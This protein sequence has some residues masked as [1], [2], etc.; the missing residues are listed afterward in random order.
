MYLFIVLLICYNSEMK[1]NN[2]AKTVVKN[3]GIL[4][5]KFKFC[6]Q[7]LEDVWFRAHHFTSLNP[8]LHF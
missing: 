5:I 1:S 8:L 7:F 2:E 6:Y 4:D 3:P